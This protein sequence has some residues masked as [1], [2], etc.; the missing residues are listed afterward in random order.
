MIT[1]KTPQE[2]DILRQGGQKLAKILDMVLARV[3]PG[4]KA[5]ELDSYA[6]ELILKAGGRPAFKGH[7]GFPGTL[8][9]S[10]NEAIVHGVPHGELVLN[11]GDVVGIDIGMQYP[12][13]NGLYTDMA[14]TVGVGKISKEAEKLIKVTEKSFFKALKVIRSGATV[15]DIGQAIQSYVESHGYSVVR[16]LS[17]HGVGYKVHEDP[18]IPNFGEKGSGEILQAGMV[19]AIEPMVCF[20]RY[21]LETL[22]DGWTAVTKDRSLTAHYENTVLVTDKGAEILTKINFNQTN[23]KCFGKILGIDYG[24]KNIGLAISDLEQQQAFVYDTFTIDGKFWEKINALIDD[25]KIDSIVVGLP[26]GMKGE[27]TQKTEETVIFIETLENNV[28]ILMETEDERLSTVEGQKFSGG[29][30]RDE[31][32]ARVI[33]QRYLD[34]K[35]D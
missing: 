28:K 29:H 13:E 20:G 35:G 32:A 8:C 27:Y 22:D 16:S 10:V 9:V 1:I 2:I 5:E 34:R 4:V 3:E 30:G 26:L 14:R 19:L 6:E 12:S 33:L 11:Q 18:K 17:G 24:T 7:E 23:K 15:G 21:E 25:E 31:S